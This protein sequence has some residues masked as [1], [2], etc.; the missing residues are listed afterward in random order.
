[1]RTL[2]EHIPKKRF[3]MS[4]SYDFRR[5]TGMRLRDE[6]LVYDDFYVAPPG[7][8]NHPALPQIPREASDGLFERARAALSFGSN[9]RF[10]MIARRVDQLFRW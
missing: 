8:Y 1:M 7:T 3:A 5:S 10:E 6:G 9:S 4:D 2:S